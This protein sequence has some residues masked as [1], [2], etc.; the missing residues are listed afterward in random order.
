MP[1]APAEQGN[2]LGKWHGVQPP[3]CLLSANPLCTFGSPSAERV[4]S[5]SGMA[6]AGGTPVLCF[7]QGVLIISAKLFNLL[8]FCI[9]KKAAFYKR[10]A[11]V[12]LFFPRVSYSYS[13]SGFHSALTP[14]LYAAPRW[15][16]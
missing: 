6:G 10:E 15:D 13:A 8:I 11:M 9:I 5:V 7:A 1:A 16:V 4:C 3:L 14:S 2:A 12:L